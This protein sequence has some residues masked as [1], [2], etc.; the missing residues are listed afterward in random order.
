MREHNG[1]G[2]LQQAVSVKPGIR[3]IARY[4]LKA[5]FRVEISF[6]TRPVVT[7]TE[8]IYAIKI[9]QKKRSRSRKA[10]DYYCN[11]RGYLRDPYNP[12]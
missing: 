5:Y 4:V 8:F 10:S 3:K 7:T 1:P 11:Q 2:L 9:T 12:L 6:L